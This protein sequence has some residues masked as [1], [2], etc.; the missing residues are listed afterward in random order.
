MR[1]VTKE[2]RCAYQVAANPAAITVATT[3][4]LREAMVPP[5]GPVYLSV[6]AVTSE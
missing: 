5:T 6:S 4:G 3:R 2:A 1:P